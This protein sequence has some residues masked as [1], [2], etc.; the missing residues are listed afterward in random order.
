MYLSFE[1]NI[2]FSVLYWLEFIIFLL[3]F[4][5]TFSFIY[6]YLFLYFVYLSFSTSLKY[7]SLLGFIFRIRVCIQTAS[8]TY[9]PNN[10]LSLDQ[11]PPE[12]R[13]EMYLLQGRALNA[14]TEH[15]AAAEEALGRATRFNLPDAWNELGECQYKKGDFTS[16]LTCFEKAL[17]LVG[18]TEG[19]KKGITKTGKCSE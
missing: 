1:A 15:S 6:L 2:L 19:R 11:V 4:F 8:F 5:L 17:R 9:M 14:V 12:G 10:S 13:G 18:G 7:R 16:A 3:L